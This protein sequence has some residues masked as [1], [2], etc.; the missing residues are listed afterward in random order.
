M[1]IHLNKVHKSKVQMVI[2]S[3]DSE[4]NISQRIMFLANIVGC[5]IRPCPSSQNDFHNSSSPPFRWGGGVGDR[6]HAKINLLFFVY[7]MVLRQSCVMKFHLIALLDDSII[8]LYAFA[9]RIN[10]KLHH[11]PVTP[12]VVNGSSPNF[13]FNNK[14]NYANERHATFPEYSGF[15]E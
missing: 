8:S 10:L 12:K 3:S 2:C 1:C 14:Q 6:N 5:P 15:P 4:V 13:T 9:P 7:L 11:N